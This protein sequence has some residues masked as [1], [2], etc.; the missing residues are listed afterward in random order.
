MSCGLSRGSVWQRGQQPT[1]PHPREQI[2]CASYKFSRILH[3]EADSISV[4][5]EPQALR[6][7]QT[8]PPAASQARESGR[9]PLLRGWAQAEGRQKGQQNNGSGPEAA[10]L[11]PLSGLCSDG[12]GATPSLRG[13]QM[14]S[15]VIQTDVPKTEIP[16]PPQLGSLTFFLPHSIFCQD[17]S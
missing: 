17:F 12:Y 13:T 8:G 4:N 1:V 11:H 16:K 10:R 6:Q 15:P 9:P 14:M 2:G 3:R 5:P 7:P